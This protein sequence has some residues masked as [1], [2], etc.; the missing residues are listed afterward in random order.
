[1]IT[2]SG[3][4]FQHRDTLKGLRGRWDAAGN[5]WRFD[6]L[7]AGQLATLRGLVGV[8]VSEAPQELAGDDDD[9]PCCPRNRAPTLIIGDDPTY[10]NHFA[11]KNPIVY[12]G[13]SSL[14]AFVD[15]VGALKRPINNG[16]TCDAGWHGDE[17]YTGTASFDEAVSL[18]RHG[19]TEGFGL[20]RRL[21]APPARAKRRQHSIAGGSVNVGR[22]LAGNPMHMHKRAPQP[23]NKVI[24][25]F[26]ETVMWAG[27]TTSNAIFRALLIAGIV[28]RLEHEG[29]RCEIVATYCA[30][31]RDAREH[32]QT[33]VRLKAPHE[34]LNLLDM[35]FAFGH[36]SF[37]RRLIYAMEGCIPQCSLQRDFRGF[38]SRAFD[39]DNPC[40]KNE[41][42]IPQLRTN[43]VDQNDPLAMLPHLIDPNA[44]P[45]TL[46]WD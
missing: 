46:T 5:C 44:L 12:F 4:T 22:L 34:R 7:T 15:H 20:A 19:W 28:D 36:P 30:R 14:S 13:F 38:I 3:Q 6:Y 33:A 9:K 41:Y 40:S 2:A 25:L 32:Y 10:L 45:I 1:M 11:D 18:A 31:R 8:V 26:V 37:G 17:D 39:D 29:Y 23:A 43:N 42:Y 27:I 16:W 35:T 24:T 21:A